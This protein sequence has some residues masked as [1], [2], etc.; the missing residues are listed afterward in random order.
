MYAPED[1]AVM[2]WIFNS[3]EKTVVYVPDRIHRKFGCALRRIWPGKLMD[4]E[5]R[6]GYTM[7]K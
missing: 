4:P 7:S 5:V 1:L 6:D 2:R 3:G